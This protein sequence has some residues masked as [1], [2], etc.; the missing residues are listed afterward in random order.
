MKFPGKFL[1]ACA[2]CA[3]LPSCAWLLA[4]D[5][6]P[7]NPNAPKLV[8]RV[9]SVPPGRNFI[10]IQSYGKWTVPA[11]TVLTTEGTEGRC[12][13]LLATGETLRQY[14]AADIQSGTIEVGDNVF[15]PPGSISTTPVPP[16]E[17]PDKP[18]IS[19]N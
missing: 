4:D 2:A 1:S 15:S 17:T 5:P 16:A 8:G 3:I 10:L 11:G 9:A 19:G 14:A 7:E 12:A 13:N 6:A 18:E